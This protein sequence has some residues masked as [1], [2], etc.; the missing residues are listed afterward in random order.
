MYQ[1]TSFYSTFKY[2]RSKYYSKNHTAYCNRTDILSAMPILW[3]TSKVRGEE[4]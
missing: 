1:L 2:F 4:I 3:Q